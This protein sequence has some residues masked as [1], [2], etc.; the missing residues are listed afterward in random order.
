MVYSGGS[1]CPVLGCIES[2]ILFITTPQIRLYVSQPPFSKQLHDSEAE[3]GVDL[4]Q[5][6]NKG[7]VLTAGDKAFLGDARHILETCDA[8]IK[9]AQRISRGEMGNLR[10]DICLR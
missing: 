6:K 5:R 3:I 4:F 8:S 9:K 1:R 10:S 2:S 7:V